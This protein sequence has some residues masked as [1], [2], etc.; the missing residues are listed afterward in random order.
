MVVHQTIEY[1]QNLPAKIR[2]RDGPVDKCRSEPH[3]HG[4]I[5]LLYVDSGTLH[6]LAGNQKHTL[7]RGDVLAVEQ[8]PFDEYSALVKYSLL[9]KMLRMLLTRCGTEKSSVYTAQNAALTTT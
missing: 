9:L 3:W 4:E 2:L 6:V 1:N 5:E 8:N 7:S